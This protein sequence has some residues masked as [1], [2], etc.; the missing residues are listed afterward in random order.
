MALIKCP[1]CNNTVSDK[2]AACPKCASPIAPT[3]NEQRPEG[4]SIHTIQETSKK[5]KIHVIYA[6][7]IIVMGVIGTFGYLLLMNING[8]GEPDG[9][10]FIPITFF[11]IGAIYYVIT[12]L[13]IW[14]H[15]K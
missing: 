6:S 2:A 11:F 7:V 8:K 12:K 4:I 10:I 9:L 3:A 5:L 1:E 14:W 15:H 13:R